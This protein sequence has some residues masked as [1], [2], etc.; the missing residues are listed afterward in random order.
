MLGV[1]G[2]S[3][4]GKSTLLRLI[5]RLSDP[6]E[7]SI[8]FRDTDV[9]RLR[10]H[11]LRRWRAQCAMIFQQFGLVRRSDVITNVLLGLLNRKPSW[12]SLLNIFTRAERLRAVETLARFGVDTVALQRTDTLSGGQQ[13]RVAIAKA[14]MQEPAVILAD[15]PIA[16]LDP[17]SS[18]QVM[19]A[20]RQV[21][22]EDGITVLCNLHNVQIARDFCD[23][24]IAMQDGR[25]VFDGMPSDL[26]PDRVRAIYGMQL[27]DVDDADEDPP[28]AVV[29]G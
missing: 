5:N 13:Q 16:S 24:I 14:L 21:N 18:L 15:E 4:A 6:T 2:P 3:G 29:H 11:A 25:V 8:H 17:R 1:I 28:L 19:R 23:R 27:D 12:M 22:R 26:T 7:G 20:L 9:S 10:G